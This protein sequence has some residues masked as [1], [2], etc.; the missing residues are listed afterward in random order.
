MGKHFHPTYVANVLMPDFRFATWH[1]APH[2][3]DAMSAHVMT[4]KKLDDPNVRASQAKIDALIDALH[5]LRDEALPEYDAEVP[6]LYFAFNKRLEA[7]V[8]EDAVSFLRLGLSRNDLDMTVYK[9]RTRE[10]LMNVIE[11]LGALQTHLLKQ[12]REHTESILIAQTHHQPGQPTTVGHYLAAIDNALSRDMDRL[13]DA[14]KRLNTCP[15]GAAA[16]AGSSHPLDRHYT[17]QLLGFGAP[18]SNTYDAVASSDWQVEF[19]GVIQS[20]SLTL[21]RFVNDLIGWASAGLYVLGDGLVQG[22]SIMPQKRNPVALEHART[23][24]SRT[25]GSAQMVLYSSHNIP[26]ADLNDFG[27]DIQGA[28]VSLFIQFEGGL[29]LLSACLEDG[30]F[31]KVKLNEGARRTDTTATELADELTRRCDVSFQ[32][33]HSLA[34]SLV[35]KLSAEKRCLQEATADDLTALG[36]PRLD[37][38]V[39]REA[40]DPGAFVRRR[41]GFGG[42]APEVVSAHLTGAETHL[43]GNLEALAHLRTALREVRRSLRGK[44]SET[45]Q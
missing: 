43:H 17:A 7:R 42:P 4:V 19:V 36:G 27:P 45:Q 29:A 38:A 2:F 44:V 39:L 11:R 13:F 35:A 33:A 3:L 28:L 6:D 32:K 31:D 23:R 5:G 15:L 20:I 10:L 25:L 18:V 1:L 9:L 22:S 21:S 40:L 8:G 24:F 26:Y 14:H 12:A 37:E 30:A 41:R 16:L 34:A